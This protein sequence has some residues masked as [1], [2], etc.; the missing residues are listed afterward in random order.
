MLLKCAQTSLN[1][2]LLAHYKE[3]FS[4]LVVEAVETLDTNLLDKDLIGIKMVTGGSVTESIL[5]RGVAFKKT[6]SYAGFEQQPKKFK[7]PKIC[8]L[9]IELELKAEKENAEIRIEN[10]DDYKSIVDA[11]WELIYEKLRKI[12]DSGANIVLSKLPIGDLATQYFADRNIFCAGR[13]DGED[14]KRIQ[15][16]TGA[17]V[18]TTVNGLTEEVLGTC[19]RF[20]E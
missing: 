16:S 20:E 12:V 11:E 14:I 13:V 5:V 10:P 15:K 6:F 19:A 8:L 4:E 7:D 1:S 9:N 18:Q 3:F 2:K 17:I